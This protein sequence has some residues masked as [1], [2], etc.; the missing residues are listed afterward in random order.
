M[1]RANTSYTIRKA[2]QRRDLHLVV[3]IIRSAS[4]ARID[5]SLEPGTAESGEYISLI[6]TVI[7]LEL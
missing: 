6:N 3:I 1:Q 2:T 4:P 5:A 7:A